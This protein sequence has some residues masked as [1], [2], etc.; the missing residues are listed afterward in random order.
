MKYD[1]HILPSGTEF[2][3]FNV[4]LPSDAHTNRCLYTGLVNPRAINLIGSGC[5]VHVPSFFQEVEA[6][7]SKGLDTEDRIYMSD[8][9]HLIF[10]LHQIC[11]GLNEA[12]LGTKSIGTTKKGLVLRIPR[13]LLV[14]VSEFIIYSIGR[15]L[16]LDSENWS[17][18]A[19]SDMV[20]LNMMSKQSLCDIKFSR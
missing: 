9:C 2:P 13:N 11:D 5:V 3:R 18:A 17:T 20:I 12:E 8:R 4:T 14:M 19:A 15:N 1:F 16:R 7:Q 10:D 6:L